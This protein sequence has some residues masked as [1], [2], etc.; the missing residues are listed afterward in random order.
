MLARLVR[1]RLT[2]QHLVVA[3]A[4]ST[5]A[6]PLVQRGDYKF[7]ED[8]DI[9]YFKS[10]LPHKGAV[11]YD[12][13]RFLESYNVCW[14]KKYRGSSKVLLRPK[15]TKEVSEVLR[16]CH[17]NKIA[18]VPQGGN[19]GLVGGGVPVFDE[20][21]LSLQRMNT[22]HTFDE[23]SGVLQC[24]AGCILDNIDLF[25]KER[26]HC[27]PLDL[28][29]KQSCHIGGNVATNA[30]GVRYLRYASMHKNVLGLEVVLPNGQILDLMNPLEKDNTGYDL[31]QLFIG[32]EGT[33]GVI[34]KVAISCPRDSKSVQLAYLAC[35]T[36]EQVTNLLKMT[37]SE[38][39]EILSAFEYLDQESV[40]LA[41]HTLPHLKNPLGQSDGIP[42]RRYYVLIET[43][44][45]NASHDAEKLEKFL[46]SSLE[47]GVILD[48][49]ISQNA[50]EASQIW[51]LREGVTE[52]LRKRG[53]TYKYDVSVPIDSMDSI[54]QETRTRLA[55]NL[56]QRDWI[57]VGYGHV[58]DSNLHLNISVPQYD[59]RVAGVLEPWIYHR[60][61]SC[62]GSISAEHGIG[63]MKSHALHLTKNKDVLEMM[64]NLKDVFDPQGIMNPYKIFAQHITCDTRSFI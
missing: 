55:Q 49:T 53:A 47:T 4:L 51:L 27:V 62:R 64:R 12:D 30:G 43:K 2:R 25:L 22:I 57:V 59:N 46:S 37:K 33:L 48:G 38:L 19:T 44:G 58:A 1:K 31:K 21:I 45:S 29:A 28:G 11:V 61:A 54:V 40:D 10:T 50:A 39:G 20:V 36:F 41:L 16:Y 24:D 13:E 35:E 32:S 26:D 7:I 5:T 42:G 18:L 60:V 34:T 3:C 17:D 56:D 52:A 8:K 63:Q 15:S 14:L 23:L 9:E 6:E